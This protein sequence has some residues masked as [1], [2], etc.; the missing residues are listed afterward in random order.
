MDWTD[1]SYRVADATAWIT[2]ERPATKNAFRPETVD[3][4]VEALAGSGF[5]LYHIAINHATG[6]L[7]AP[8][9]RMKNFSI[10]ALGF[11]TA[12][13]LGPTASGFAIDLIGN[14]T[15]NDMPFT[16][17]A[18]TTNDDLDATIDFGSDTPLVCTV[19]GSTVTIV[20]AGSCTITAD[21]D[22]T[23]NY[24]AATGDSETFTVANDDQDP[25]TVADKIGRAHV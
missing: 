11:S 17:T 4:L 8:E 19:A 9:D 3:E 2:I 20:A 22:A 13:F 16:V 12:N 6:A 23:A 25:L 14:K 21:S 15:Y 1:I 24:N 5:M 10:L 18:S 7:G